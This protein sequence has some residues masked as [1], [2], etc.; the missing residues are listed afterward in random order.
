M[1]YSI[2]GKY[3]GSSG[4]LTL[5]GGNLMFTRIDGFLSK[6]Q[7]VVVKIPLDA[8]DNVNVEGRIGKKLVILVDSSKCRGIPRHE[9]D[10]SNPY[11]A[12]KEIQENIEA[13]M[14]K[15]AQPQEPVKEIHTREVTSI[16]KVPCPF[17]GKLNEVTENKCSGCG[18]DVG[19]K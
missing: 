11:D 4:T 6:T 13:E 3:R 14:A 10:V 1:T 9:F 16:V 2:S 18:A 19:Q 17:C 5:S 15:A 7:R 12:M 8:I